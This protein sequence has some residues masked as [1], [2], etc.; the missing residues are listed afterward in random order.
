MGCTDRREFGTEQKDEKL[1][2]RSRH[3]NEHEQK[4]ASTNRRSNE[5]TDIC[6][7]VITRCFGA[8][9][10]SGNTMMN[11]I[12]RHAMI[13]RVVAKAAV[14]QRSMASI[15]STLSLSNTRMTGGTD[16]NR[17]TKSPFPF[18]SAMMPHRYQSLTT[19][20]AASEPIVQDNENTGPWGDLFGAEVGPDLVGKKAWIHRSF[21][22]RSNTDAMLTCG[23]ED[24]AKHASF[25]PSYDRA[26]SWI[27]HHAVGPAVLSPILIHGLVG[28]LVE[29]SVPQSIPMSSNITH[30]C[31]LIVGVSFMLSS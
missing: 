16:A 3:G 24:L 27:R 6:R 5:Q 30:A 22:A 7:V 29:A 28:A 15:P 31:P 14:P 21:G 18:V 11:R 20:A 10:R 13:R 4:H 12:P 26:R 17:M 8:T 19:A 23:G 2:F 9:R 25:D 1:R